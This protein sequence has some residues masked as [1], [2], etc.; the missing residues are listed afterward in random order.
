MLFLKEI[1]FEEVHQ[2]RKIISSRLLFWLVKHKLFLKFIW[3]NVFSLFLYWNTVVKPSVPPL[4]LYQ[5]YSLWER[6][7]AAEQWVYHSF[8]WEHYLIPIIIFS[9]WLFIRSFR[10]YFGWGKERSEQARLYIW[11]FTWRWPVFMHII[12]KVRIY[13]NHINC[14][15]FAFLQ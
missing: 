13:Y 4:T 1:E 14:F 10:C 8:Y 15:L 12:H 7:N 3:S 6:A 11:S 5:S 9:F 2:R